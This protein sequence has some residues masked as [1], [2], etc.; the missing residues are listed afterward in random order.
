[1]D[2]AKFLKYAKSK[3]WT[4]EAAGDDP[5]TVEIV[6]CP[7]CQSGKRLKVDFGTWT[8]RCPGCGDGEEGERGS[9]AKFLHI[10]GDISLLVPGHREAKKSDRPNPQILANYQQAL[11]TG[12]RFERV[13]IFL[14][15]H[16]ISEEDWTRYGLGAMEHKDK[17]CV[18]IPIRLGE[19]LI[20]VRFQ[21]VEGGGKRGKA[22]KDGYVYNPGGGDTE[23]VVLVPT[24]LDALA[25]QIQRVG[26]GVTLSAVNP[27]AADMELLGACKVISILGFEFERARELAERLGS[28]RCRIVEWETTPLVSL[29]AGISEAGLA[30]AIRAARGLLDHRI[31]SPGEYLHRMLERLKRPEGRRGVATGWENVDALFGGW[32]RH[33]FTIVTGGTGSGKTTWMKSVPLNLA[34]AGFPVVI[35]SFENGPESIIDKMV[36]EV[37]GK[38]LDEWEEDDVT[39][40]VEQLERLPLKFFDVHG[41]IE[42]DVLK[43]L[44]YLAINRFAPYMIVLDNLS[45]F[46]K[47]ARPEYERHEIERVCQDIK[48]ITRKTGVHIVLIHHPHALKESNP[49]VAMNDLKGSSDIEKLI[50]NGITI[51]RSRVTDTVANTR[52][53]QVPP[54]VLR[55]AV[56]GVFWKVRSDAGQEGRVLWEFDKRTTTYRAL[57]DEELKAKAKEAKRRKK[58][59]KGGAQQLLPGAA[60]TGETPPEKSDFFDGLD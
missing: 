43:D 57:T 56:L 11:R 32:R 38:G 28:Y 10:M 54:Y 25:V 33:E 37:S 59:G 29:A 44:V 6:P 34:R 39:A 17:L 20:N 16:G 55:T 22:V 47:V 19:E 7:L 18:A 4:V 51:W 27:K 3:G 48:E 23:N 21:P 26:V 2:R 45:W 14:T 53:A 52:A 58:A 8:Y 15:S 24:E 5:T 1:V 13:R 40:G 46:V 41:R 31:A 60:G 12:E 36:M 30:E 50:D 42:W 49:I 35:G 9:I